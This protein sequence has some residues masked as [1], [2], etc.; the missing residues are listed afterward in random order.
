MKEVESI[1]KSI[2]TLGIKLTSTLAFGGVLI[3]FAADL[4]SSYVKTAIFVFI[5]VAIIAAFVGLFPRDRGVVVR[6]YA[7]EGERADWWYGCSAEEFQLTMIRQWI[8]HVEKLE[9]LLDFRALWLKISQGSLCLAA[10]LF[11]FGK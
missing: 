2:D 4:S 6:A 11:A 9:K 3:K 7:F 10:L 8:I 5:A 1:D